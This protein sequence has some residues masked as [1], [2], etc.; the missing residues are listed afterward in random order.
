[1]NPE[2]VQ[3]FEIT[4]YL[5]YLNTQPVCPNHDLIDV[6]GKKLA[7]TRSHAKIEPFQL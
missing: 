5:V 3:M 4:E 1:M 2:E 7:E 6:F